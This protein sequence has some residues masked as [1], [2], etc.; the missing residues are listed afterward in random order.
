[1]SHYRLINDKATLSTKIQEL[2]DNNTTLEKDKTRITSQLKELESD[3]I[4]Y[5]EKIEEKQF[6]LANLHEVL[7]NQIDKPTNIKNKQNRKSKQLHKKRFYHHFP[8]FLFNCFDFDFRFLNVF[9]VFYL[10]CC[11]IYI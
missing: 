4:L 5:L 2:E 6:E 8:C 10:C 11:F 7:R 3:K 1:M 9:F